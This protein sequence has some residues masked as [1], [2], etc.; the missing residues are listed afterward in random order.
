MWRERLGL[1][2]PTGG[3]RTPAAVLLPLCSSAYSPMPRKRDQRA[4]PEHYAHKARDVI[5]SNWAIELSEARCHS[6]SS[7]EQT[8][9]P[10]R[11]GASGGA[12]GVSAALG[13]SKPAPV[14]ARVKQ[15]RD[16]LTEREIRDAIVGRLRKLADDI[17][18][19]ARGEL[20]PHPDL[21]GIRDMAR[22]FLYGNDQNYRR[23][24][25]RAEARKEPSPEPNLVTAQA[26]V[27]QLANQLEEMA[28]RDWHD[29]LKAL[30]E[31]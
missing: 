9:S 18:G 26:L 21:W 28:D 12:V 13:R 27:Q 23:A 5:L 31:P 7:E 3:A 19:V 25:N 2:R 29:R 20:Q 10:G 24:V 4:R 16:V 17:G 6:V 1:E 15:K 11:T 14:G 22:L 8:I 30:L